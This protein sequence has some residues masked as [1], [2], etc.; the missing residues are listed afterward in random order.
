V[1]VIH[2]H[3]RENREVAARFVSEARAVA[4][5]KHPNIVEVYDVSDE[6]DD[7][8]YLVVELV[9]GTTLRLLL[10]Q[11]GHLPAEVAAAITL[12]IG[13]GLG[14]AHEQAVVHR[15]VKPENV[16]L[17]MSTPPP[18]QRPSERAGTAAGRVKITDFGIA[19]LLDAQGVT[20]TGQVLGSPAH[21]A[22]EQIE[23]AEV[24][25]RADV[26]GVGVL[27]YEC[28]VGKL[29]FDGKNP[30]QVLRR[31]LDGN[32]VPAER[33]RPSV[34][35]EWSRI[36]A[37]ALAHAA[38]DRYQSIGQ[39]CDEIRAELGR[40]GFD[41]PDV[42]LSEFLADAAA[43]RQ[44]YTP[45]VVQRLLALG[46]KARSKRDLQL[47]ASHFN[48]ALAL[49]PGDPELLREVA[50]LARRERLARLARQG[51]VVSGLL[52]VSTGLAAA[53]ARSL[54][55]P[56][57]DLLPSS[58]PPLKVAPSAAQS[59]R[60]AVPSRT[61]P[62]AEPRALPVA[63]KSRPA[64]VRA[65][66][67]E[68]ERRDVQVVINPSGAS[69]KIDGQL[70]REWFG[71]FFSLSVG[72]HTFEF[73]PPNADCCITPQPRTV[74]I[75]ADETGQNL[76][77]VVNGT[78]P[79]KDAVLRVKAPEGTQTFCAELGSF[80]GSGERRYPMSRPEV[81]KVCQVVPPPDHPAPG[82]SIDVTLSAGKTFDLAWP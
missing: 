81:S 50:G 80:Q 38:K 28:M 4:K 51:A 77:Q 70:E 68:P 30:A 32:Y 37:R 60:A 7:E 49:C 45:R 2:R 42:E 36:I 73:V 17:Q 3:L 22:P 53:V 55:A 1:K 14:R 5:V 27:L 69:V 64:V 67:A 74:E 11:H 21:M 33:A 71:K 16:L 75:V 25:A 31:V 58:K 12:Q 26:F 78:I 23:G 76:P 46:R 48:R 15:D 13:A 24:D 40:L 54:N 44:A 8:R 29:P 72:K 34:G 79:F 65:P 63:P 43:Y 82:K 41:E 6:A 52:L 9:R 39:M 19:K 66:T 10:S 20:S 18:S 62:S 59:A 35:A 47:A 57:Q 61:T 56:E